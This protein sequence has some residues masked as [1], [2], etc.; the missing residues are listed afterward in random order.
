MVRESAPQYSRVVNIGIARTAAVDKT[1]VVN[2]G[3]V[4]TAAVDGVSARSESVPLKVIMRDHEVCGSGC[5]KLKLFE[6]TIRWPSVTMLKAST[7][8][9]PAV[10]GH[11]APLHAASHG[12]RTARQY[13]VVNIGIWRTA[14][15]DKTRVVNIGAVRTA[16]VGGVSARS[17]NIPMKAM[18]L[19]V[20]MT[21]RMRDHEVCGS[22]CEK[23]KLFEHKSNVIFT[24]YTGYSL[25]HQTA[26]MSKTFLRR[27]HRWITREVAGLC[28]A[29]LGPDVLDGSIRRGRIVLTHVKLKKHLPTSRDGNEPPNVRIGGELV[30]KGAAI[31]TETLPQLLMA[32]SVGVKF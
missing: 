27:K 10:P 16:A 32:A 22:G 3:T 6:H 13:R 26:M 5:E 9:D 21:R 15:V 25:H 23:L 18:C 30:E 19:Q 11:L 12:S 24:L 8:S 7:R 14:A 31:L 28:H 2:I 1:R 29:V 4:R 20:K 17:E